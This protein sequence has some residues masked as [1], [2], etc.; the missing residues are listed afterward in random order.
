MVA[1]CTLIAAPVAAAARMTHTVTIQGELIN[2]WTTADPRG[3]TDNGGGTL[4]VRFRTTAP[5]RVLPYVDRFQRAANGRWG[6][7]MIAV[8]VPPGSGI[9]HMP[10]VPATG[11][12]TRAD[13]TTRR[14]N[15]EGEDC[16]RPDAKTGC[17]T[18]PLRRSISY[19]GGY[20][21][22]RIFVA[23]A[24][25]RFLSPSRPCLS[26]SMESW[27]DHLFTGGPSNARGNLV[28]RMPRPATL[29]RRRVVR[30][31]G[32]SHKRT[33]STTEGGDAGEQTTDTNDVTRKVTVTFTRR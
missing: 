1:A 26:G 25:D 23:M 31:T 12:I 11:S 33:T 30:V 8:P 16:T 19:V 21:R 9:K 13:N 4:T 3:C 18:V 5:T 10:Y 28:V 6:A 27:G 32:S 22:T 20:D 15:S 29:K 17:G 7:W 2:N 24:G 14:P